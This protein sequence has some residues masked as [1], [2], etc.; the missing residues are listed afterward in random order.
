MLDFT[1]STVK[2]KYFLKKG[3]NTQ[4]NDHL[5]LLFLNENYTLLEIASRSNALSDTLLFLKI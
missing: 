2:P 1:N 4:I 3:K 5:I